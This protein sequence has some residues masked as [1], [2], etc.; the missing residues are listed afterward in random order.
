[1]IQFYKLSQTP[2]FWFTLTIWLFISNSAGVVCCWNVTLVKSSLTPTEVFQK[3]SYTCIQF[4]I[5]SFSLK[6]SWKFIR[7]HACYPHILLLNNKC[8]CSWTFCW[9]FS[10]KITLIFNISSLFYHISLFPLWIIL[11]GRCNP[12]SWL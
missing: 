8:Q 1:M 3:F 4:D 11:F 10:P 7:I 5:L 2:H 9:K 12:S 6:L